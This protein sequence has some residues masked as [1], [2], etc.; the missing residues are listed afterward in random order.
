M[1]DSILRFDGEQIY[2]RIAFSQCHNPPFQGVARDALVDRHA[3][4]QPGH[5]QQIIYHHNRSSEDS[6][7]NLIK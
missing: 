7:I 1:N 5:H 4:R 3:C 6:E 2:R